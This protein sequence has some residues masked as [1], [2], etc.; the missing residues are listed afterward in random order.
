[1]EKIE[2]KA[3]AVTNEIDL[4]KIAVE[5]GIPR[6]YTWEEPLILMGNLLESIFKR[7]IPEKRGVMVFSFGSVVFMNCIEEEIKEFLLYL[8]SIKPDIEAK[9]YRDY[10]DHY[11]LQ[12]I[13]DTELE[14]TN[15]YVKVPEY[16][17][18]MPELISIIIAKSTALEKVEYEIGGIL[19]KLEGMID[20]LE[21][22]RFKISQKELANATAKVIRHQYNSIAYIMILDKPDITWTNSN[23]EDLYEMLIE[24]F[25]LKD[26]YEVIKK[27]TDILNGILNNFSSISHTIRGLFV[28]WTIVVLIVMEVILMIIDLYR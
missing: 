2:F 10:C 21:T 6:K 20:R 25:E 27:K 22:A 12:V 23:A 28:D 17:V 5:C 26:R 18:Y 14:C 4:N 11:E 15:D 13:K 7:S 16:E 24:L 3:F 8:K 19:D 1:M 9:E